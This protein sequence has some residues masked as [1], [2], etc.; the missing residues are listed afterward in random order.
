MVDAAH[1]DAAAGEFLRQVLQRR[2][3]M[4]RRDIF[5]LLVIEFENVPVRIVAAIGT[6]A[7]EVA[8]GPADAQ[9]RLLQGDRASLERFRRGNALRDAADS[10]S[11]RSRQL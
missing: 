5:L 3:Q 7:A 2:V 8:V 9:S 10:R 6:A 4:R 11:L 1:A